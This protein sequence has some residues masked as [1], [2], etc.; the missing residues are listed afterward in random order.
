MDN[1]RELINF[2]DIKDGLQISKVE[3]LFNNSGFVV[4]KTTIQNLLRTGVISDLNN[5]RL[6]SKKQMV[7][8]YIA[9]NLKDI[10]TL[11]ELKLINEEI[12]NN[13][14]YMEV[15]TSFI[16][17]YNNIDEYEA[18]SETEKNIYKYVNILSDYNTII[19]ALNNKL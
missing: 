14:D 2:Y 18:N 10:F 19:K 15:Y 3:K 11:K 8:L 7:E 12:F 17:M 6:Y 13:N 5:G 4:T 9:L 1:I 16:K